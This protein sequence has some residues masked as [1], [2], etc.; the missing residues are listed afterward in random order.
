MPRGLED[1]ANEACQMEFVL[2]RD[3]PR[4]SSYFNINIQFS[5]HTGS[6]LEARLAGNP[7]ERILGLQPEHFDRLAEREKSD[8]KWQFLLKYF[9]VRLLVKKPAGMRKNLVVVVVDMQAIPLAKLTEKM[10]VF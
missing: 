9:E 1:C 3:G 2:G 5:D 8:L 7:A 6:L 10:A 4:A